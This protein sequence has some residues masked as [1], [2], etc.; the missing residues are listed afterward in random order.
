MRKGNRKTNK[1]NKNIQ[2][3]MKEIK[4]KKYIFT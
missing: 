1:Q 3:Y 2:I 4:N